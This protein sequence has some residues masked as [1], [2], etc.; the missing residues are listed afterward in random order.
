MA[1]LGA[2]IVVFLFINHH[3]RLNFSRF[4]LGVLEGNSGAAEFF[5]SEGLRGPIF[6]NYDIGGYLIYYLYLRERV[7]V[8]NRPEAYTRDFF[9]QE[10]VPMQEDEAAWRRAEQKYNFNAIFFSHRDAAPWGQK[11]LIERI[12]DAAWAPV[13]LDDHSIIFLKRNDRNQDIIG[14]YEIAQNYF[15]TIQ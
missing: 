2:A 13:F 3:S 4:G 12:R 10:Y 8:D 1:G 15:Q 7:F 14:K 11:F 6:N 5:Q 9:E